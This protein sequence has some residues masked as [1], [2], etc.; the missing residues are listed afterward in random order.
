MDLS[1]PHGNSV[2]AG[3]AKDIY[4]DT[5]FILKLPTIDNI[6]NQMKSLGRGCKLYK[7]DISRAFHHVKLNPRDYDWF[8]DTCL[9]FGY[10]H[11]SALFQRLS[12][13][14]HHIMHQKNYDFMNYIDD[15]L[16]IDVPSKIDA[17][18]D[19]LQCLL[20]DL[21]FE[22]SRKKLMSPTT[23]MNCL[24]IVVDTINFTLAIPDKNWLR[25]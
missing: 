17:S 9:P 24:G 18:F 1:F 11:D 23:S 8:L 15:I 2:N 3:I 14:V 4:L 6:T 5:P 20:R 13:A 7:V 25:Y 19:V 21:G 12:D 10:Q 22:I 16:G